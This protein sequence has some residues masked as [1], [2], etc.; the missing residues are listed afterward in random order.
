MALFWVI[1]ALAVLASVLLLWQ[2]TVA[3]RF[4]LHQASPPI[5][6]APS[7][8]LLKP[9]HGAD[10]SLERCLESWLQQAHPA[11]VEVLVGVHRPDDP[12]VAV[13][14]SVL[15]RHPGVDARWVV[16]PD[17]PGLNQKACT[18]ARL[19]ELAR[20][21]V[22]V[23]SDADVLARPGLLAAALGPLASPGVGLANCLYRNPEPAGGARAWEALSLN[24]DFWSQ[25]L[26]SRSL[27]PQDFALGAVM[28]LRRSDLLAVGGFRGLVDQLADDF[29]LGRR[30]RQRG[31]R[32]ELATMVA[33]CIEAPATAREVWSHQVRWARTIRA[34]RPVPFFLS[35][36]SN[37]SAWAAGALALALAGGWSPWPW[38]GLL[39]VRASVAAALHRR[40]CP[41]LPIGVGIL[42]VWPKDIASALVWAT[43][44]MGSTVEWRG[45]RFRVRPGGTLTEA[46]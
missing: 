14:E 3:W 40:M 10:P 19:E 16:C 36:L 8:S 38:V 18:L 43:A 28:A 37:G 26:Q 46:N 23:V 25:V 29:H 32:I 34:C 11:P 2:W 31:L 20:N 42:W 45:R 15:A 27:A 13:V 30:M 44:F 4:P 7:V 6:P 5:V 22:V 21:D 9:V 1:G 33:D 41:E 12:A 24:V 17:R 39:V 35:I